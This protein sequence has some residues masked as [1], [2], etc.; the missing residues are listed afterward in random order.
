ML[1]TALFQTPGYTEVPADA[2]YATL[3]GSTALTQ[4]HLGSHVTRLELPGQGFDRWRQQISHR[5]VEL[6]QVHPNPCPEEYDVAHEG[7][8]LKGGSE[9]AVL[10]F[11]DSRPQRLV[12]SIHVRH[13]HDS[14]RKSE[15]NVGLAAQ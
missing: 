12:S 9:G 5:V 2:V 6:G 1:N 14:S 8:V 3:H 13:K 7:L 15:K 11:L 4:T 10:A